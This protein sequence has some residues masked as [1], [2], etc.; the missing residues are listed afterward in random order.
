VRAVAGCLPFDARVTLTFAIRGVFR[1]NRVT[2][3]WPV[4]LGVTVAVAAI[5]RSL[6]G[7]VEDLGANQVRDVGAYGGVV[8]ELL[9]T[10]ILVTVI[11]N[12]VTIAPCG[13]VAACSRAPR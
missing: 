6:A 7:D 12:T 11:L 9:I 2:A 8:A 4:P 10:P 1:Q 3:S 13:L 5:L